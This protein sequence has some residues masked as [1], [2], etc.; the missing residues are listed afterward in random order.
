MFVRH[1]TGPNVTPGERSRERN[2]NS[3]SAKTAFGGSYG[4][5]VDV[6]IVI[7]GSLA[8]VAVIVAIVAIWQLRRLGGSVDD[9]LHSIRGS[10]AERWWKRPQ[11]LDATTDRLERFATDSDEERARLAAGLEHAPIGILITGDDGVV[12]QANEAA[13]QFLGAR[14]GEAVA[15]A[16]MREAID[17]AILDRKPVE[18]QVE[19]LS[20]SRR[21]LAIRAIPFDHGVKS[22]GA[23]AY[24]IDITEERRVD[25][26]RRDF[27][28][29]VGHELK[30]PLGAIAVLGE[31]IASQRDDPAV[32]ARLADRLSSEA[33]RLSK[34]I[35]DILDLSQAEGKERPS[36]SLDVTDVIASVAK[37]V[38]PQADQAEA[39]VELRDTPEMAMVRGDRRQ[40]QTMFTNIVENAIRYGRPAQGE[41]VVSITTT[42]SP[43][44]VSIAVRDH[45]SGIPDRHLDR[46]FERFYRVDRDRSRESGGTGLGLSI[47]RH[48]ARNHGGDITVESTVGVGSTFTIRLPIWRAA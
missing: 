2:V 25:A 35:G 12:L 10:T 26:M 24:L 9:A 13:A 4:R 32:L 30:T 23:V 14:H 27:I 22:L 40:L 47:A 38:A 45:G 11:A 42:A 44:D 48:I 6:P 8:L 16:R 18:R 29:N 36:Q 28:A 33:T 19:L 34:L 31:T 17:E 43:D 3:E 5:L 39:R 15:E 1:A 20:P 37:A 46:I 41:H 7:A 21:H